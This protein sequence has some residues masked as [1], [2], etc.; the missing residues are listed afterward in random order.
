MRAERPGGGKSTQVVSARE[1]ESVLLLLLLDSVCVCN[2]KDFSCC[3][4]KKKQKNKPTTWRLSG[5][6]L[7]YF[8]NVRSGSPEG[9]AETQFGLMWFSALFSLQ[10]SVMMSGRQRVS[11]RH[12]QSPRARLGVYSLLLQHVIASRFANKC[13]SDAEELNEWMN[14]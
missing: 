11:L 4:Y 10:L 6:Q 7:I 14:E 13:N 1:P 9:R 5:A 8:A 3:T 2:C 12:Q